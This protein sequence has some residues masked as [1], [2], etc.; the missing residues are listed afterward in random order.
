VAATLAL[1]PSASSRAVRAETSWGRGRPSLVYAPWEF[2]G[3]I[4]VLWRHAEQSCEH[5]PMRDARQPLRPVKSRRL[6]E[7]GKY[8]HVGGTGASCPAQCCFWGSCP[9]T[10][11]LSARPL[12]LCL[13]LRK[14]SRIRMTDKGM[15]IATISDCLHAGHDRPHP[16]I[17]V[18]PPGPADAS[19]RKRESPSARLGCSRAAE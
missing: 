14:D 9:G 18:R 6:I 4:S 3:I 11:K 13:V 17:R 10:F 15:G 12:L 7:C 1:Y 5:L 16:T 2:L 19:Q 8:R